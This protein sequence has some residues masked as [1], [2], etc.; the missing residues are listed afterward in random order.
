VAAAARALGVIRDR[1]SLPTLREL[2]SEGR[3][4]VAVAAMES[5]RALEDPGLDELLVQAL[6]QSDEE[7][8]KEALRAIAQSA[9]PRREARIALGLEHGAWDVR[10]L[11]AQLLARIGGEVA[12]SALERRLD[13]ESDAGVRVAIGEALAQ[14]GGRR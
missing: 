10:Q 4:G 11:A 6:G 14:L 5:L 1:A 12:V 9:A 3:P 8:V 13:R 7:L 2:V